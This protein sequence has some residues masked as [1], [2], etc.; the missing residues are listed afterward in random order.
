MFD[1][2]SDEP[3]AVTEQMLLHMNTVTGRPATIEGAP[4]LALAAIRKAHRK[5]PAPEYLGR[6]MATKGGS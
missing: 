6:V 5:M 3:V 4:A 1:Y 2:G